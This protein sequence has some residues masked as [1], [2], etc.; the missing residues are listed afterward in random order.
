MGLPGRQGTPGAPRS[1]APSGGGRGGLLYTSL[2]E[3]VGALQVQVTGLEGSVGGGLLLPGTQPFGRGAAPLPGPPPQEVL[4][5]CPRFS[6]V[7]FSRHSPDT[8]IAVSAFS[9]RQAP[10]GAPSGS[11]VGGLLLSLVPPTGR[12]PSHMA[13]LGAPGLGGRWSGRAGQAWGW[14][15][16]RHGGKGLPSCLYPVRSQGSAEAVET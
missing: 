14:W 4:L 13:V 12:D 10:G 1:L 16:D 3:A 2:R 7:A 5:L 15:A 11:W 9:G 6:V 8:L